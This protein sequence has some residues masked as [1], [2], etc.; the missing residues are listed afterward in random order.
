MVLVNTLSEDI[1]K[2]IE[3]RHHDPFK[4]LGAHSNKKQTT[5]TVF[6]P[7]TQK[8]WLDNDLLLQRIEGT[9]VFQWSGPSSELTEHYLVNRIAGNG[10]PVSQYDPYSFFAPVIRI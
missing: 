9:D 8:A 7:D 3:A 4:I 2:I 5:V 10:D 6:L 1:I